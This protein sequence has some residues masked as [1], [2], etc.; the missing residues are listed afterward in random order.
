[1]AYFSEGSDLIHERLDAFRHSVLLV[2]KLPAI[3]VELF[4][5]VELACFSFPS[6]SAFEPA[7]TR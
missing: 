1:M 4:N 5:A 7:L 2:F 3:E 6:Q